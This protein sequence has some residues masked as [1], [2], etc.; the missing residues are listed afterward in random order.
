MTIT[1][2]LV[3]CKVVHHILE[4]LTLLTVEVETAQLDG[5]HGLLENSGNTHHTDTTSR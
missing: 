4:L 3:L 1:G 5:L 2:H